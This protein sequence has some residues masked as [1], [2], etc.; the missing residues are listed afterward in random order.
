MLQLV[1]GNTTGR[2]LECAIEVHKTLGPG[3]LEGS[4]RHCLLHEL[5]NAGLEA[6][7]EVP[8]PLRYKGVELDCGYR[9]DVVVEREVLLELKTVESLLPIHRAQTPPI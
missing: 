9:A 4:Y 2:I 7:V 8:I 3:L 1:N 5:R 6:E